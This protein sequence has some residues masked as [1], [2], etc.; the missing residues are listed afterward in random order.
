[1]KHNLYDMY[2]EWP[3]KDLKPKIVCEKLLIDRNGKVPDDYKFFCFSGEPR[4]VIVHKDRFGDYT[5]SYYDI[6]W[7]ELDAAASISN[8]SHVKDRKPE[9]YDEM[10]RIAKKLS[11]GFRHVR[12]DLYNIEGRIYFGEMTFFPGSGLMLIEPE[13]V[14]QLWG[15]WIPI[16]RVPGPDA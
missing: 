1:M 12:V 6:E 11:A 4:V 8:V 3:Y 10:I 5:E 14:D 2:R 15:S 7:N 9:G 13:E 16:D